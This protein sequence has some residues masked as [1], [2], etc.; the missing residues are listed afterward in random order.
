MGLPG[1]VPRLPYVPAD[2]S[3]IATIHS[4]L[5]ERGLIGVA[6]S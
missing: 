1:G 4:M 6:A 3:E 2:E 5:E